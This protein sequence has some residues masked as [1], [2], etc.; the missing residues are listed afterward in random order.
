MTATA[1]SASRASVDPAPTVGGGGI[2]DRSRRSC[3]RVQGLTLLHAVAQLEH[4]LEHQGDVMLWRENES[5]CRDKPIAV[6]AG[7][8]AEE[9]T[10]CP[11]LNDSDPSDHSVSQCQAG[12]YTRSLQSST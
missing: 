4:L 9:G 2:A 12:A 5:G 10:P 6:T 7:T 1:A 11:A 3:C 8:S